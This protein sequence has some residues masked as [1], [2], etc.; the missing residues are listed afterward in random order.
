MWPSATASQSEDTLS[1]KTVGERSLCIFKRQ[2]GGYVWEEE[3]EGKVANLREVTFDLYKPGKW[4]IVFSDFYNLFW[5]L[6]IHVSGHSIGLCIFFTLLCS[7]SISLSHSLYT[8]IVCKAQKCTF[9]KMGVCMYGRGYINTKIYVYMYMA[10][11][12]SP[13]CHFI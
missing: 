1:A 8:Y 12:F 6:Y 11:I 3:G 4:E 5:D 2:Q 7:S 13:D 9:I 10:K